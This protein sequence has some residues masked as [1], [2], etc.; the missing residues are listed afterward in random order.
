MQPNPIQSLLR[1]RKFLL[2]M[3]DAFIGSL[4][5]I[6]TWFLSPDKVTSVMTIFGLWQPVIVA[7]ILGVAVEDAANVKA[8]AETYK[9]DKS[10]VET[11]I[12]YNAPIAPAVHS[13]HEPKG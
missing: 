13:D 5:L 3:L 9:A 2:A 4:S 1:S 7:V 6:L 8:V 10:L 11:Q 12:A